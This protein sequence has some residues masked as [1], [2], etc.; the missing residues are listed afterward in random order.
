MRIDLS[1]LATAQIAREHNAER[2][3]DHPLG[4][5]DGA[6]SEDRTTFSSD[7]SSVGSL[8]GK[9][10]NSPEIRHELVSQLKQAV[11]SGQYGLDPN[12]IA[13]SMLNERG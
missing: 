10:M 13:S 2:A 5:S 7:S 1:Q 9:A 3:G 12:A 8:V 11:S 4:A 6:G